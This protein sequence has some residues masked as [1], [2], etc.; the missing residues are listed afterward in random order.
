M[1]SSFI[2]LHSES[3]FTRPPESPRFFAVPCGMRSACGSTILEFGVWHF[4]DLWRPYGR[5]IFQRRRAAFWKDQYLG[6]GVLRSGRN[7]TIRRAG[8]HFLVRFPGGK[9]PVDFQANRK[10]MSFR[11]RWL[12]EECGLTWD[13]PD[14]LRRSGRQCASLTVGGQS[15]RL[16]IWE[17]ANVTV[18]MAGHELGPAHFWRGPR[19]EYRGAW[20]EPVA[21][22]LDRENAHVVLLLALLI[23]GFDYEVEMSD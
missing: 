9:L 15:L 16:T 19:A 23:R 22:R 2:R 8:A 12:G 4:D 5:F 3:E 14:H 17:P 21:T 7:R 6:R 13:V 1:D 18:P 20:I 11:W 10:T